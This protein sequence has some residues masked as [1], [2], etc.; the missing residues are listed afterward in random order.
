MRL[1]NRP[2]NLLLLCAC[3]LAANGLFQ[4]LIDDDLGIGWAHNVIR[5]WE[6]FGFFE[7]KGQLVENAGGH[8]ALDHPNIYAGMRAASL[9]PAFF[10]GR[11]FSWTGFHVLPY[12]V[13]LSLA[14]LL[15]TWSLL[16]RTDKA[17]LIGGIVILCPGYFMWPA[18]MDPNDLCIL[19]GFP[20]LAL[21]WWQLR[22]R[23]LGA[24]DVIFLLVL[25]IAYTMLNWSTALAHG[26]IFVT[27]AL[28]GM[29]SRRRLALYTA[30]GAMAAGL[31]VMVGLAS[32]LAEPGRGSASQ[33]FLQMLAGYTWGSGGY[34]DG[35]S[36]STL[37]TRLA[38]INALGLFPFWLLWFCH[39]FPRLLANPGRAGRALAPFGLAAFEIAGMRN[40][41]GHHP[42]MAGPLLLFA[43]VLSLLLVLAPEPVPAPRTTPAAQTPAAWPPAVWRR[44]WTVALLLT[45]AFGLAVF[46]V[47]R[48]HDQRENGLIALIRAHTAR[49]DQILVFNTRDPQLAAIAPRLPDVLD[50]SLLVVDKLPDPQAPPSGAVLLSASPMES[51]WTLVGSNSG[52][53]HSIPLV[54]NALAWF[55]RHISRRKPGDRLELAEVHYLYSA[56]PSPGT[57]APPGTSPPAP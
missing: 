48:V 47:D 23:R 50:R 57:D 52:P 20:Y 22:Q 17:L 21:L 11:L 24:G 33:A 41:F 13:L 40:Y 53:R 6:Q 45:F 7:L 42:W 19:T 30:A 26:L 36:T 34:S 16:G 18:T 31:V 9:Y 39:W 54:E 12:H 1:N 27:L 55:T 5:N 10:I 49:G 35:S 43:G 14:V 15:S 44:S 2:L 38:F 28:S 37:F 25:T 29:L 4:W 8:G 56:A 3:L 46:L 51:G 32:K